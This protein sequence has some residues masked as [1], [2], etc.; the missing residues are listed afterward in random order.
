M[1]RILGALLGLAAAAALAGCSGP[2]APWGGSGG[3]PE[4]APT[5]S[6]AASFDRSLAGWSYPDDNG[7]DR[8]ASVP[9]PPAEWWDPGLIVSD[10][11]FFDADSMTAEE[12]QAFLDAQVPYC[13]TWHARSERES[14]SGWPY[15]C[16]KDLV[17][18]V[19]A[20]DEVGDDGS[21]Y[22][23]PIEGRD[24][25]TSAEVISI[26]ATA[27]GISPRV[28][29]VTLEKEQGLVTDRWPWEVQY[30]AATGYACYD[31]APCVDAYAGFVGQVY[32]AA[33]TYQLY[34]Q[35]P[36]LF[37]YQPYAAN[38]IL[39]A[40]GCGAGTVLI[41]NAATAALYDYT[42]YQP[43]ADVL[44]GAHGDCQAYGNYNFWRLWFFWFG[45]PVAAD[46]AQARVWPGTAAQPR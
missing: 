6:A 46:P 3:A 2:A 25:A 29:L 18:T 32:H 19:P 14:D 33:R 4:P 44:A 34:V 10:A 16:L 21:R 41:R 15:R 22:C 1:R 17:W 23:E 30:A 38:E 39:Y 12:I 36:E 31:S 11:N 37:N 8:V 5:P 7:V 43:S 27:C 20:L 24:R 9:A 45:D 28:L 42:P 35:R 40:P 13:E 26:V